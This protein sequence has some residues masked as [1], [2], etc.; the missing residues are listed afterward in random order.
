ML[1]I[2]AQNINESTGEME[3]P[4]KHTEIYAEAYQTNTKY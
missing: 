1:F 3:D 4:D 2:D